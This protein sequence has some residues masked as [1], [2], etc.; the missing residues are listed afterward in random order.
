MKEEQK[1]YEE[2][3]E[4]E[5]LTISSQEKEKEEKEN[6]K[7]NVF[8]PVLALTVVGVGTFWY[9]RESKKRPNEPKKPKEDIIRPKIL[10]RL[11]RL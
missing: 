10:H 9:Y 2:E 4:E 7:V 5:G 8:L 1:K 3:E 11:E 6:F